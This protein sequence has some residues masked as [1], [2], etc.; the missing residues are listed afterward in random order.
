M[1]MKGI[2][3]VLKFLCH[4]SCPHKSLKQSTAVANILSITNVSLCSYELDLIIA[5]RQVRAWIRLRYFEGMRD[6]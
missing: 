2:L 1:S 4:L 3:T 5:N 6:R